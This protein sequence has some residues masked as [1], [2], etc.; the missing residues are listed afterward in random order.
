MK[1]PTFTTRKLL[2]VLL[3]GLMAILPA[4]AQGLT[5]VTGAMPE[6]SLFQVQVM[7]GGAATATATTS[8][9][10]P[11]SMAAPVTGGAATSYNV[12]VTLQVRNFTLIN[13]FATPAAT[14][15]ATPGATATMS[16]TATT[17]ATATPGATV[18]GTL[19]RP[20]R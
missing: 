3:T 15:T 2:V 5:A 12:M 20:P 6:I 9:A 4:C 19:V 1:H 8:A 17:T 10:G 13:P 7:Q 11:T 14:S 16:P 18:T